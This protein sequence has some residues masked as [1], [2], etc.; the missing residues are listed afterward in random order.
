MLRSCPYCGSKAR[1]STT[2]DI[3]EELVERNGS[4][5]L[6]IACEDGSNCGAQVWCYPDSTNYDEALAQATN[7]WNRRAYG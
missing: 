6:C 5:A 7:Q 1:V 2:K 3:Y 4:A